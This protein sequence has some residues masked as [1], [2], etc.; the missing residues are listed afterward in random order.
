MNDK[1][2]PP[3]PDPLDVSDAVKAASRVA[4]P[5][6]AAASIT[7]EVIAVSHAHLKR[8]IGH[9]RWVICALLFFA[10]T[11]N[12]VDRQ[13]FG[14]LAPEMKKIFGWTDTDYTDIVFWFEVAYAIGLLTTGR[15][16]DWIGTRV[17]FAV[18]MVFWSLAAMLHAGMASIAGFSAA[19]FLLGLGE[20][21]NF[22]ACIKT[23]A[24]WF[25]KKERALATGIF[26]A[27]SNVGA[28]VAPL[29]VPWIYLSWG[30]QWAFL[31]TG[32]IGF[33]W[34]LFWLPMFRAPDQHPRLSAAEL[35]HIRSDPDDTVEK[36]PWLSLLPHRQTWAFVIAK[37]L[38]D[39]I[40][41]WYLY[42]L[43][44]F[45]STNFQLDIKSFGPP[46]VLIYCLADV[47][48]I[49]G[50]WLSS[51]LIQRGWSV[52][53]GRKTAMLVC[54][55]CVVPVV[56]VTHVSNMWTAVWLVG[57]AAAAHQGWSANLFTTA[58]DMF[59]RQAVGSI[60]GL[61]GMAGALGAMLILKVTGYI[62]AQTGSY[63]TLFLIAGSA[64]LVA[65]GLLHALVPRLEPYGEPP[66]RVL[67]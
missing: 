12:Y 56:L 18:A 49:G 36:I 23:V 66:G 19:R 35:A 62:L 7:G 13:V 40:W 38:T 47:G 17:G 5:E 59:P 8:G 65:L 64:Y 37:F 1:P 57:L 34:L 3:P 42:L 48:S 10:T 45:F 55:L 67:Q 21:G 53:A 41:R 54:A 16:L 22:P 63:T 31:A 52:N 30:W 6:E 25:P 15:L 61:G 50:G 60:V 9:Y 11:I 2:D 4:P 33:V 14:I 58:S 26:N 28:I 20:A 29:A 27:G 24:E 39:S 51:W 44:L 32:A 46:F 43:P